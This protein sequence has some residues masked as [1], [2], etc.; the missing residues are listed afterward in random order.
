MENVNG[1]SSLQ[2]QKT[3]LHSN[4]NSQ[5]DYLTDIDEAVNSESVCGSIS[6][7]ATRI[8]S[9]KPFFNF[10]GF[11]LP[12]LTGNDE[13]RFSPIQILIIVTSFAF[14]LLCT[15]IAWDHFVHQYH[16][17][18]MTPSLNPG[19]RVRSF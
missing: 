8:A 2:R 4:R 1:G 13:R 17:L 3:T 14:R 16:D 6:N 15:S 10:F 12:E 18:L 7:L 19:L 9:N 11:A 5:S